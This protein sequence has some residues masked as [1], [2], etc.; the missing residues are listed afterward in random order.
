VNHKPENSALAEVK[1][2]PVYGI[3]SA[4]GKILWSSGDPLNEHGTVGLQAT[5]VNS[6][7]EDI[8]G[9]MSR[10]IFKKE[11]VS[12]TTRARDCPPAPPDPLNWQ[13]VFYPLGLADAA[14]MSVN[15][16][17]PSN[18]TP[19]DDSERQLLSL[20]C[21]DCTLK[22]A[23]ERMFLSESA[24]DGKIKKLKLKLNVRNIGGLVAASLR[25]ALVP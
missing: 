7:P 20:L 11:I 24:I 2:N 13:V 8:I 18:L 25:Y 22:E 5:D 6:D 16:R 14:I 1:P 23:A 21:D 10:C 9:K 15:V 17:L 12:F 3:I 4:A 19:I